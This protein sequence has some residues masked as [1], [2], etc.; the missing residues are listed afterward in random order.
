MILTYYNVICLH[1]VYNISNYI[2]SVYTDRFV[3]YFICIYSR[4]VY[5]EL[6]I[7]YTPKR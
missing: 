6:A 1:L 5:K 7:P 4:C 3:L 2:S